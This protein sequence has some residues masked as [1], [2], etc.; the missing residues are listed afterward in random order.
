MASN[1]KEFP[2]IVALKEI[3]LTICKSILKLVIALPLVLEIVF[4]KSD[5]VF[6]LSL[7]GWILVVS[8]SFFDVLCCNKKS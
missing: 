3:N 2:N 7:G 5:E 1:K 8:L 4:A 6:Y